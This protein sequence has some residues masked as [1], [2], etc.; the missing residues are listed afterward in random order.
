M[1]HTIL[2]YIDEEEAPT[3]VGVRV[4]CC[5]QKDE[6]QFAIFHAHRSRLVFRSIYNELGISDLRSVE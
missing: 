5:I 1:F 4:P 3:S 6:K 2:G